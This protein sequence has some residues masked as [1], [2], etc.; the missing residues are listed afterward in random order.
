MCSTDWFPCPCGN[1]RSW[2]SISSC[3]S[4]C[5]CCCLCSGRKYENNSLC[6]CASNV[7]SNAKADS[8]VIASHRIVIAVIVVCSTKLKVC[9][10]QSGNKVNG[11][12][13]NRQRNEAKT[14]Q[15]AATHMWR[16]GQRERGMGGVSCN[17]K[18]GWQQHK[19]QRSGAMSVLEPGRIFMLPSPFGT[20]WVNAMANGLYSLG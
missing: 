16:E 15:S 17:R 1:P 14:C 10:R 11:A 4:Y 6:L 20:F 18:N 8:I 13:K 7:S 3:Y 12:I 19:Q 5:C 9:S 2:S